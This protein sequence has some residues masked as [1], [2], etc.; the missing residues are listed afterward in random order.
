MDFLRIGTLDFFHKHC[1]VTEPDFSGK[2]SFGFLHIIESLVFAGNGLKWSVILFNFLRKSHI[3]E[4]SGSGD[5]GSKALDQSD[6][7][8]L[9]IGISFEPFMLKTLKSSKKS[10][11]YC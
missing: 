6:F 3:R 4:K 1:K 11:K 8:I 7:A 2:F 10:K 9:Q 5:F